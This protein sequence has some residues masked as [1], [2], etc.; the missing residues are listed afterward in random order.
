MS[1]VCPV[2]FLFVFF[3]S[4]RRRHTRCYRD[5]SSD[6]C[7]SDL[8]GAGLRIESL[9]IVPVAGVGESSGD[10]RRAAASPLDRQVVLIGLDS[11]DWRIAEPLMKR[12]KM[13]N[14]ERLIARGTRANL[15]TIRPIL[16]PVIWTSIAT[17]VKPSRHGIVDFV[18]S[19]RDSGDL[20]PVT[21]AMR[22]VPALWTLLSRQGTDVGVVGWWAT[23][24]AET[25]RGSVVSDRVAF[26]L[27]EEEV[28]DDWKSADQIGR[29]HV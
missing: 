3:F 29:A 1:L 17:G 15:K 6:V 4:S 22:Q 7:S 20:V 21:S 23:W 16:S 5:W 14:L 8:A 9:R 28:K 26:Q 13:P 12:G 11:F 10:I 27:F 25:V 2:R 18:V 24:P 19:A